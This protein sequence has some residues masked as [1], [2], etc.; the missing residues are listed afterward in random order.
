[1]AKSTTGRGSSRFQD[2]HAFQSVAARVVEVADDNLGAGVA[3][4]AREAPRVG[5]DGDDVASGFRQPGRDRSRALGYPVHQQHT[6]A[7][8]PPNP[9]G[10]A[11]PRS[12]V[13]HCAMQHGGGEA[14]GARAAMGG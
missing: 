13:G 12:P 9:R 5:R 7:R 1:L 8:D 10:A 14:P 6:R 2:A 4:A 11:V 3:D